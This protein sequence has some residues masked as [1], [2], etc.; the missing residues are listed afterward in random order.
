MKK[1]K[2]ILAL[3]CVMVLFSL[4]LTP[5]AGAEATSQVVT[6]S[7]CGHNNNSRWEQDHEITGGRAE[8]CVQ[9]YHLYYVC[10]TCGYINDLGTLMRTL[11]HDTKTLSANC[12]GRIQTYRRECQRCYYVWTDSVICPAGPHSGTC[13]ALSM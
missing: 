7:V 10:N 2:K 12:N 6:R 5:L 4:C 1:L 3:F 9:R 8:G 11:P 13:P